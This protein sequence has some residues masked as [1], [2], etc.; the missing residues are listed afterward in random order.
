MTIEDPN[1]NQ[2]QD[3]ANAGQNAPIASPAP[4]PVAPP[5]APSVVQ[6]PLSRTDQ[7]DLEALTAFRD[8]LT[9]KGTP[10]I[11][12]NRAPPPAIKKDAKVVDHAAY[13]AAVLAP[14]ST[15]ASPTFV[16]PMRDMGT[17]SPSLVAAHSVREN[18]DQNPGPGIMG[19]IFGKS[20]PP[21][22]L[23]PQ[24][25]AAAGA[26][27]QAPAPAGAQGPIV[28]PKPAPPVNNDQSY[29]SAMNGGAAKVIPA[30]TIATADPAFIAAEQKATSNEGQHTLNLGDVQA[31]S[32]NAVAG[33][34]GEVA[35]A[36][37]N[38][39]EKAQSQIDANDS[40]LDPL[41][42]RLVEASQERAAMQMSNPDKRGTGQRIA[43]SI[44]AALSAV[45]MGLLKQSGPNPVTERIHNDIQQEV[46]RQKEEFARQGTKINDA[47]N[48]YAQIYKRTGDKAAAE[49]GVQQVM[50]GA[51]KDH[52]DQVAAEQG[53]PEALANAKILKDRLDEKQA[54]QLMARSQRVQAQTVGGPSGVDAAKN[55]ELQGTYGLT[56]KEAYRRQV[57]AKGLRDPFPNEPLAPMVKGG[58][59][60]GGAVRPER[61]NFYQEQIGEDPN[62]ILGGLNGANLARIK[63]AKADIA[64]MPE[65]PRRDEALKAAN[66]L[67]T[68]VE[69]GGGGILT[70][71]KTATMKAKAGYLADLMRGASAGKG[72]APGGGEEPVP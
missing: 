53:G 8:G 40:K 30:H 62:S 10:A 18:A 28:I 6:S 58:A 56:P 22:S 64:H 4:P 29:G 45:G 50:Y 2:L 5:V 24:Q 70:P 15:M 7:K 52:V 21:T 65:G 41:E 71:A 17:N 42:Q 37:T 49:D 59:G 11:D 44:G 1:Q 16:S 3:I 48:I 25:M 72:P 34:K 69:G 63:A 55:L 13:R 31:A 54:Q 12:P 35:Q 32:A 51:A 43:D 47:S 27:P 61:A 38:R 57:L 9:A 36:A 60:A 33:A 46:D 19:P 68:M 39:A 23:G 20:G 14:A 66:E 26:A 67:Q